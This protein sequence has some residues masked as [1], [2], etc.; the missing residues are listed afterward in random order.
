MAPQGA[1]RR[2]GVRSV[3]LT[4]VLAVLLAVRGGIA[5]G[6][7]GIEDLVKIESI[8]TEEERQ[9]ARARI[10]QQIR[11]AEARAAEAAEEAERRRKAAR[12]GR[13]LER[14]SGSHATEQ[15]K[16]ASGCGAVS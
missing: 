5:F 16:P 4:I 14:R 3:V 11:E 15:P 10:Q 6:D 2:A 12:L 13:T 7:V 9:A 8:K 1:G